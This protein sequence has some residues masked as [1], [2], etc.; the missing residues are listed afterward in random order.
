MVFFIMR[1]PLNG[2]FIMRV[3]EQLRF[4]LPHDLGE[5]GVALSLLHDLAPGFGS[6]GRS[7]DLKH[8]L[9]VRA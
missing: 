2:V 5:V 3:V 7:D 1:A 8:H 6:S 4:F 9:M